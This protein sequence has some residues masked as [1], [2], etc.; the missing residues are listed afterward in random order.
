MCTEEKETLTSEIEAENFHEKLSGHYI[1]P[2][3]EWCAV[4]V[5]G[6]SEEV[7]LGLVLIDF[8]FEFF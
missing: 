2:G 8:P 6:G 7:Q 4:G 3:L 1:Q 5:A